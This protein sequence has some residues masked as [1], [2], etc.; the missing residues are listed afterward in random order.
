[1]LDKID[2]KKASVKGCLALATPKDRKRLGALVIGQFACY[3]DA[4]N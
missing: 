4:V 2:S 3:N 1:M